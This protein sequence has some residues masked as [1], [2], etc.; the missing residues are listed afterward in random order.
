MKGASVVARSHEWAPG[1][2]DRALAVMTGARMSSRLRRDARD[3][4]AAAADTGRLAVSSTF[5]TRR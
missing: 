4:A 3:R 2:S 5:S 1:K